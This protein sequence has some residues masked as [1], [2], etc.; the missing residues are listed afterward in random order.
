MPS[1]FNFSGNAPPDHYDVLCR[2]TTG[3]EEHDPPLLFNLWTDPGERDPLT[4]N[5]SLY[6]YLISQMKTV[7]MSSTM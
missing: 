4:P 1:L 6:Y 2:N 3:L 7:C 5:D